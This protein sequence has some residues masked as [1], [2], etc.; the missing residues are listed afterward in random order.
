MHFFKDTIFLSV[1][2]LQLLLQNPSCTNWSSC[3]TN[4][5]LCDSAWFLTWF[6][7]VYPSCAYLTYDP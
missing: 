7:R 3:S 4:Y 6:W 1:D 5:V 2:H